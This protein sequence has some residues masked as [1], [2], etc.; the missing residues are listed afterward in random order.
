[1]ARPVSSLQDHVFGIPPTAL[2]PW[3]KVALTISLLLAYFVIPLIVLSGV[4]IA[5]P[6]L[7]A[8]MGF[9]LQQVVPILAWAAIFGYLALVYACDLRPVLGLLPRQPW[10]YVLKEGILAILGTMIIMHV[11][12]WLADLST[13]VPGERPDPYAPLSG[14]EL[15]I[16][17]LFAV[18]TAPVLEEI[19]FRGFVQSTLYKSFPPVHAVVVT[20]AVFGLLHTLYQ[21][22]PVAQIAVFLMGLLFGYFRLRTGTIFAGMIAHLFNNL[23]AALY[24]LGEG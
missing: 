13:G 20:A 5:Q 10:G 4:A 21:E 15:K 22:T 7:S 16:M 9:I 14:D 18:F 17:A 23:M 3:D 11:S 2:P 1:M 8:S 24:L 19:V 6:T 12:A